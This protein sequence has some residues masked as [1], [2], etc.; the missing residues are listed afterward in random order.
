MHPNSVNRVTSRGLAADGRDTREITAGSRETVRNGID[1][2]PTHRYRS[3][4]AA[5]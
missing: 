4:I 2:T 5:G 3:F 1:T